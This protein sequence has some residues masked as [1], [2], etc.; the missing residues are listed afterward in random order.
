MLIKVLY[1]YSQQ[2]IG[3]CILSEQLG[4]GINVMDHTLRQGFTWERLPRLR[5]RRDWRKR[6]R[7]QL[8]EYQCQAMTWFLHPFLS[9][10][11]MKRHQ[12]APKLHSIIALLTNPI[13]WLFWIFFFTFLTNKQR[14]NQPRIEVLYEIFIGVIDVCEAWRVIMCGPTVLTDVPLIGIFLARGYSIIHLLHKECV[15]RIRSTWRNKSHENTWIVSENYLSSLS[16]Q[17]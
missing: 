14:S 17:G 10:W 2:S 13:S 6:G 4:L 11:F 15:V 16:N 7:F 8:L 3:C 12:D 5:W 1:K 9:A